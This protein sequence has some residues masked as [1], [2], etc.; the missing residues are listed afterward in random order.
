MSNDIVTEREESVY[1]EKRET[2]ANAETSSRPANQP[3]DHAFMPHVT[4]FALDSL[5]ISL[6]IHS[7]HRNHDPSYFFVMFATRSLDDVVSFLAHSS[8]CPASWGQLYSS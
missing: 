6:P 5:A 2:T 3:H 8:P 4:F 1:I 7:L